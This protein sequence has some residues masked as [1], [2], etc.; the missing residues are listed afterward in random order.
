MNDPL[1]DLSGRLALVTGG[2]GR[3]GRIY[4]RALAERGA[5][6]AVI[7]VAPGS[8]ADDPAFTEQVTA[9]RITLLQADITDR[10]AID[11]AT[12]EIVERL[13]VPHILVNNAAIDAPPDAPVEENGPFE[14]YPS[15]SLDRLM[16]VN[17]KGTVHCCQAVGARMS[18]AGRG[19]IINISSIYGLVSPVQDIYEF[20][21]RDGEE[22]YKPVGYS[23][24][25]SAI[26][27]LTRYLATYWARRGVRVNT[28]TL[29]GV[30]DDQAQEFLDAYC[31]R[32]PMGRMARREEV[33]GPLL[34]LASDASSYVTGSNLVVD[35][36]WT[37]W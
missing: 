19:S 9:G 20:R 11:R 12:T 1:F 14:T 10:G 17:V 33:V 18:E 24:S 36:G 37:A 29:A 15:A 21:R 4:C 31:Q 26:L 13:G 23:V 27:N 5:R 2:T 34:F 25:K 28:L 16:A 32:M 22:F 8:A 7:D 35:G 30:F 6:V 3:L